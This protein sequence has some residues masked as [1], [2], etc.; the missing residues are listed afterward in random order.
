MAQ[1]RHSGTQSD[2]ADL[3]DSLDVGGDFD[4]VQA[5]EPAPKKQ[6]AQPARKTAREKSGLAGAKLTLRTRRTRNTC[7]DLRKVKAAAPTA[8]SYERIH[9]ELVVIGSGAAKMAGL[10]VA[11]LVLASCKSM[12]MPWLGRMHRLATDFS[13]KPI[14]RISRATVQRAIGKAFRI[15]CR[16]T[17]RTQQT[18]KF[19]ANT[20]AIS[21]L[22]AMSCRARAGFRRCAICS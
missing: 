5:D 9:G 12:P 17:L 11:V 6:A 21:G 1:K 14:S 16:Q 10:P 20:R 18:A 3:V 22:R 8:D 15:V 19:S 4:S 7:L 13:A 2:I